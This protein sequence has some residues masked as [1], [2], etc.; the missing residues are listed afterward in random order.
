MLEKQVALETFQ[1]CKDF[2]SFNDEQFW[3]IYEKLFPIQTFQF[4]ND[5]ISFKD[6]HP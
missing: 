6:E 2:I 4:A 5:F 1:F 3:N